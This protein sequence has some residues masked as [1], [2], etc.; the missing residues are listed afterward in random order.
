MLVQKHHPV[1]GLY[2][3]EYQRSLCFLLLRLGQGLCLAEFG[4]YLNV[5]WQVML[6]A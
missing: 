3:G 6:Q 4:D 1:A 2:A 5:R